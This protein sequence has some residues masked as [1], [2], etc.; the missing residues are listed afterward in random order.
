M[1]PL[2]HGIIHL[3]C[4]QNFNI[5]SKDHR[6]TRFFRFRPEAPFLGKFRPKNQNCQFKLKF[7]T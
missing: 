5:V 3:I 6:R 1:D 4:A 2:P 7:G